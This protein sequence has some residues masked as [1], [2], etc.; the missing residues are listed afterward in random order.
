MSKI[1]PTTATDIGTLPDSWRV[2]RFDSVFAVQQGKQVSKRN[3]IGDNHRPFLRTRNVFWGR[4]ELSDLDE[5]NFSEEEEQR[6]ALQ[7][8]DLLVC[9]GGDIGRAAVWQ[10]ERARCYFQN[11]LHRARL[12]DRAGASQ[13]FLYWLWFAFEIGRVYFG[14]GNVTTIPNLSQSKLRELPVPVPPLFEQQR[15]AGVLSMVQRAIEQQDHFLALTAEL[16]RALLDHLFTRGL[17]GE[18]Q[19]ETDIG[20]VPESWHVVPLSEV[21]SAEL[22]NG[23]FVRRHQ[24]GDG[25]RFANVVDMY[26]DTYLDVDRL[27]RVRPDSSSVQQYLLNKG[28]VLI[29][30]SSLKREGIGQN[31]VVG[32]LAEPTIY[33]CHLIR[34]V[35]EQERLLP[36]FLSAYWRSPIGKL[37]LIQRSKTVTMTTINQAG[38]SGALV[39]CPDLA[40]Q[41][42]IVN[43]LLQVEAKERLHKHKQ[44][45]LSA[46]FRTLLHQLMTAQIRV[47][48]LDMTALAADFA[49]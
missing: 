41:R 37:D 47:D 39:P 9:E 12:L 18:S 31:C 15:I 20:P 36:E 23:A 13:F 42:D 2:G 28:D 10:G 16:R 1:G 48:H 26:R 14:R 22:Q 38:I 30:R 25:V 33:D 21:L 49:T 45:A 27:Q 8:G 40:E 4:L 7:P 32:T 3:R 46:L 35:P 17:R 6:L 5:M 34:V 44:G 11:H 29:V 43:I 24:F 19:K